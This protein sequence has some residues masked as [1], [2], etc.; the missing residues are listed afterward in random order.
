MIFLNT[1]LYV[2]QNSKSSHM[3][4]TFFLVTV[5]VLC[6]GIANVQAQNKTDN[7]QQYASL[8][9]F[10]LE[11]GQKILDCKIGYRTFGKLN[12]DKSNAIIYLCG[13]G[14]NTAELQTFIPG[15]VV[16]TA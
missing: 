14:D 15:N 7:K 4:A 10:D 5:L 16:D 3:K 8:G 11:N 1:I 9:N 13:F 6:F 12:T 2:N